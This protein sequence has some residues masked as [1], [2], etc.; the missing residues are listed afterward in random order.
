M[1]GFALRV[2][3]G[4]TKAF[5]LDYRVKG[6]GR[7]RRVTIGRFPSWSVSAARERAKALRREIDEGGDPRGDFEEGR[8]APTIDDLIA[9]FCA[10]HLPKKRPVTHRNY[11][12]LIDKHIA[13]ALGSLKVADVAFTD[14]DR[15]HRK[16]S[17]SA[18]YNANRMVAVLSKMFALAI[19]WQ[20]RTDNPAKG[21]ERNSEEKRAR[22]LKG[23]ELARLTAALIEHPD[24]QAADFIRMLLLTGA[25][26]GETFAMR[27]TDLDLAEGIWAEPAASTK[28]KTN[29]V[30][31]SAPARQLLAEIRA[32]QKPTSDFVFPGEGGIGHIVDVKK[33]WAKLCKAAG[34]DGLRLHDLRHSFA[35]QLA[36]AGASLPLIGALLGHSNDDDA[37]VRAS[38]RRPAARRRRESRRHHRR[39][40]VSTQDQDLSGQLEALKAAGAAPIYSEKVSGTRAD[41]PQLAKLMGRADSRR[42]SIRSSSSL[43][44][45]PRR[46][47]LL[48][49]TTALR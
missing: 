1:P 37:P 9:R 38:I 6:T 40:R 26:R 20:M 15:L 23:D 4:G 17:A 48:T 47:S 46:S 22:Y 7:Q 42:R 29:E 10:E 33:Q 5:I 8:A 3:A 44:E 16:V 21:I 27:W 41:R 30:P 43:V 32:R 24:R 14:I 2:T 13:P 19:R 39:R 35:S 31:L 36:S 11:R 34:I 25:R 49:T 18:P 45:R 12:Y 28:Q